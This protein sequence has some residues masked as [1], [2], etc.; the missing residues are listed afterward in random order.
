MTPGKPYKATYCDRYGKQTTKKIACPRVLN[1]YFSRIGAIDNHNK[2]RQGIL[3]LEKC[4]RTRDGFFRL[5]TTLLGMILT[6]AW[7]CYRYAIEAGPFK[8]K[9]PKH[10]RHKHWGIGVKEYAD[11]VASAI[12]RKYEKVK[13]HVKKERKRRTL[14]FIKSQMFS[15]LLETKEKPA[16]TRRTPTTRMILHTITE[17]AEEL[18]MFRSVTRGMEHNCVSSS[19]HQ[20]LHR[21]RWK[22]SPFH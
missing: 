6:D 11:I 7:L 10:R 9:I 18:R 15:V 16:S 21:N 8:S 5:F 22:F 13:T 4:W 17:P 19:S 2:A 14:L 20:Q 3:R 12:L 1:E